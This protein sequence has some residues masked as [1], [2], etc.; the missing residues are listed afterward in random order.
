VMLQNRKAVLQALEQGGVGLELA[1]NGNDD[2]SR[3]GRLCSLSSNNNNRNSRYA[4]WDK[5]PSC[6]AD[7]PSGS[8]FC[9]NCG[10]KI[11]GGINCR[12]AK[13]ISGRFKI[14]P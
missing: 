14:L 8:K 13:Q 5:M 10:S 4:R 3:W 9:T 1:W 11:A 12:N 2:A 6:G 7:L